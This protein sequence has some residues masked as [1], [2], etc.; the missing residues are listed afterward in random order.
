[1]LPISLKV[2][3]RYDTMLHRGDFGWVTLLT[4]VKGSNPIKAKL[5]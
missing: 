1:M 5:F 3:I 2:L 4:D